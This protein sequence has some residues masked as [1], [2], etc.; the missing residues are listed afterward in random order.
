MFSPVISGTGQ[1]WLSVT[2]SFTH[3]GDS[4]LEAY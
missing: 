3:C 4:K 1:V 2:L